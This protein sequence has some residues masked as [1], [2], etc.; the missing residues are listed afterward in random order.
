MK[1]EEKHYGKGHV[2]T[3]NT[4]MNLGNVYSDLHNLE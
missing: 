3:A 2:K 1:I 4:L